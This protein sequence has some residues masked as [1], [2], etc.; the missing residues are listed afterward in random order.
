MHYGPHVVSQD[1]GRGEP[2]TKKRRMYRNPFDKYRAESRQLLALSPPSSLLSALWQPQKVV[3]DRT[4]P[5]ACYEYTDWLRGFHKSD[6][7]VV[8]P[9]SYRHERREKHS[10]LPQMDLDLVSILSTAGRM[11]RDDQANLVASTSEM[12]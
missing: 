4:P 6:Q 11:V 12:T 1:R 2:V 7:R 9:L 8:D 3:A 10:W 5:A